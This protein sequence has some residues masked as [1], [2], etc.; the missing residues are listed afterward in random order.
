MKASTIWNR[1][2]AEQYTTKRFASDKHVH[3]RHSQ[4]GCLCPLS[5]RVFF[6]MPT[7]SS[8]PVAS[9][10]YAVIN[11][12]CSR[13]V[14]LD[15]QGMA[16]QHASWRIY[17]I[18]KPGRCPASSFPSVGWDAS[19]FYLVSAKV[20]SWRAHDHVAESHNIV[21]AGA[22]RSCRSRIHS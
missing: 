22:G 7:R 3:H 20:K 1:S 13:F 10:R 11:S 15:G 16:N 19:D 5:G 21:H 4:M 2:D 14:S 17:A 18:A 8:D 12:S 9:S 6:T